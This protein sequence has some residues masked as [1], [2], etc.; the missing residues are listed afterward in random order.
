[1]GNAIDAVKAVA[2]HVTTS[3]N[4]DGVA[5]AIERYALKQRPG[6]SPAL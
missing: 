3:N 5:V 2:D 1:M 4:E 6:F